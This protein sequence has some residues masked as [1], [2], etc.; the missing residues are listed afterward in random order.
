MATETVFK[1]QTERE[2]YA[3]LHTEGMAGLCKAH[4][5][6]AEA[7]LNRWV[8]KGLARV[9]WVDGVMIVRTLKKYVE[10]AQ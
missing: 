8:K 5:S 9:K 2:A 7:L 6:F 10:V 4:P 3:I 1:R